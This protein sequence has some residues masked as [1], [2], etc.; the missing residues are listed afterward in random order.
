MKKLLCISTAL[1]V[2]SCALWAQTTMN[3]PNVPAQLKP[4]MKAY[5]AAL[6]LE[7]AGETAAA[8]VAYQEALQQA[9]SATHASAK[10]V[11]SAAANN[12][13]TLLLAKGQLAEAEAMFRRAMK[14]DPQHAMAINNLA[15]LLLRQKRV[16]EAISMYEQAIRADPKQGMALNNLARLLLLANDYSGAA[17]AL[18]ASLQA[19]PVNMRE[20][21]LLTS[22]V[23]EKMEQ[24]REEQDRIWRVLL[25]TTDKQ[26]ASQLQLIKDMLKA[27]ARQQPTQI[28]ADL[29]QK[30]PQWNE[31]RLLQA[32]VQMLSNQNAPALKTIQEL[33]PLMKDDFSVRQDAIALL[34]QT[35]KIEEAYALAS[36]AV[37]DFPKLGTAWY[38]LG[39]VEEK[40]EDWKGAEKAYYEATKLD[41]SLADGWNNLGNVVSKRND[42]KVAIYAYGKALEADPSHA[43][44]KYNLARTLVISKLDIKTGL[45]L[46]AVVASGSSE[47]APEA[48]RFLDEAAAM[49]KGGGSLNVTA[50]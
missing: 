15:G 33:L 20:T 19:N 48:K 49:A 5:N 41:A 23:Y 16:D 39:C 36:Q 1:L 2:G 10:V 25:A 29:L 40:R 28:L 17:K 27:G 35:G 47:V 8:L 6:E 14:A 43:K 26:P 31:A 45:K 11:A 21:L 3:D 22:V 4:A 7:Q 30:D 42:A 50:K 32:R 46:M 38:A 12:A 13:G 44:A 9:E 37:K 24:P 18:H 34:T